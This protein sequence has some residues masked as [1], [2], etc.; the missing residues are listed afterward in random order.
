MALFA[1]GESGV[2]ELERWSG[3][4]AVGVVLE[5]TPFYAEA[6]G[7]VADAGLLRLADGRS[8]L[9]KDTQAFAGFVLHSCVA[10]DDD[11][12]ELVAGQTDASFARVENATPQ[13][14]PFLCASF[15]NLSTTHKTW[16][17]H[18]PHTQDTSL[19]CVL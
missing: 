7:Q 15:A 12:V 11:D 1:F 8:L 9:V 3:A 10:L 4:G 5:T 18:D 17:K 6:G 2:V 16:H 19:V 13:D 14:A